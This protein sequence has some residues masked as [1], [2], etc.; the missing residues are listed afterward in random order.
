MANGF[1]DLGG[2]VSGGQGPRVALHFAQLV[3]TRTGLRL[4]E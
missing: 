1:L 3:A 2:P 4:R